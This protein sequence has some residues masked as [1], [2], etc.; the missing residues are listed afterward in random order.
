M[1][2]ASFCV[3]TQL[4]ENIDCTTHSTTD[5]YL[6]ITHHRKAQFTITQICEIT[7]ITLS[8]EREYLKIS[9]RHYQ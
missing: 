1:I 6:Q 9:V 3:P 5:W 4:A 7:G 8:N 2:Y